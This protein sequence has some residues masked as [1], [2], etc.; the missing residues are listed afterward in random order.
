MPGKGGLLR[1]TNAIKP[2][3]KSLQQSLENAYAKISELK[4]ELEKAI[5]EKKDYGNRLADYW[6]K[7]DMLKRELHHIQESDTLKSEVIQ[8]LH[9]EN[10]KKYKEIEKMKRRIQQLGDE[11]QKPV[12]G[13]QVLDKAFLTSRIRAM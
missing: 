3:E 1:R 13:L 7:N 4:Q 2:N 10:E 11:L 8:D 9:V 6:A 12:P 5:Q